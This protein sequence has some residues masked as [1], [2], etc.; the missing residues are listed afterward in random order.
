M[1]IGPGRAEDRIRFAAGEPQAGRAR[2]R[3]ASDLRRAVTG[4]TEPPV[5]YVTAAPGPQT[6][7]D[8]FRGEWAARLPGD[9]PVAVAGHIPLF[10]DPRVT[11]GV[12]EL[13]GAA[14]R[15]V[16]ELGPLEGGHTYMLERLGASRVVAIEACARAYLRCLVVK[17]LLGL[18]AARFLCGDFVEHLRRSADRY[19][20][21]LASGVLYHVLDP[22][23]LIALVAQVT[24]R[25]LVWTHY[26]DP[27]ILAGR[28]DLADAF[29]GAVDLSHGGYRCRGHVFEYRSALEQPGFCGGT[30]P[31]GVWLPRADVLGCLAHFGFRRLRIAFEDP[32]HVHGP[33]FAVAASKACGFGR[34][35][36]RVVA[37]A[38]RLRRR[39]RAALGRGRT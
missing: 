30:S 20:L 33:C 9:P 25:L 24:D 23:E 27:A 17:E 22:V 34:L 21:V 35:R 8:L 36:D 32:G 10:E 15:T 13:G 39:A 5:R 11:W 6:A 38:I 2:R 3:A 14:G 7:V 18:R 26:H 31:H 12:A 29:T 37:S 4:L 19:D 1:K 28:A 16:L